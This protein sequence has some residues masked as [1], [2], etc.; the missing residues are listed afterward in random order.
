[1]YGCTVTV[2]IGGYV[3]YSRNEP[4]DNGV[5]NIEKYKNA[6]LGY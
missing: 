4:L 5:R 3:V 1:M 2:I 6:L